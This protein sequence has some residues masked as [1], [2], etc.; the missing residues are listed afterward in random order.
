MLKSKALVIACIAFLGLAAAM[1][2]AKKAKVPPPPPPPPPVQKEEPKPA[3]Q[4]MQT[5]EQPPDLLSY[6]LQKLNEMGILK[7]IYFDF[8]RYNIRPDQQ[9]RVQE[10]AATLKKYASLRILIEGHCDERGSNE[11]NMAL[12]WKRANT[13]KEALIA[14]G[15]DPS[16]IETISYGEERPF[17]LCHDESCWSQNRRGHFVII[18]K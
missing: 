13:V 15:V 16:R 11:Y 12:G 10:D 6:D 3:E 2:C 9:P 17:A 8:D 7:D 18:A 14:L 4:Q 5:L 1:G